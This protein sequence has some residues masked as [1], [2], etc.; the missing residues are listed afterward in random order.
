MS[1]LEPTEFI[2]KMVDAGES[3]I[4]MSTK[5]TVIRAY[6]AGS[7]AC[8]NIC[9]HCCSQNWISVSRSTTLSSRLYHVVPDEV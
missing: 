7:W 1:Y 6:M 9:D 8:S 2:K 3:K 5:D 4:Y